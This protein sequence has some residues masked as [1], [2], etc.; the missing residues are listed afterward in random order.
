MTEK[1]AIAFSTYKRPALMVE[2]LHALQMFTTSPRVV[3]I[4]I[5]D[6][7]HA[8]RVVIEESTP[9]K[10]EANI[11]LISMQDRCGIARTKNVALRSILERS[12]TEHI[13]VMEDDVRP[14]KFGWEDVLIETARVNEQKHLLYLPSRGIYG[15]VIKTE[16][17][18]H[19]SIQWKPMCSGLIMYFTRGLLENIGLFEERF[20]APY[21]WEHNEMTARALVAQS[22]EPKFYPH[23][24][25][26]ER[27]EFICSDDERRDRKTSPQQ[28]AV[29]AD[30]AR[31]NRPL[32]DELYT[33]HME[34][35]RSGIT[36]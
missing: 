28:A 10:A 33:Q 24:F 23:C 7:S 35:W 11:E 32:Y 17:Q 18:M 6:A 20:P 12:T 4:A 16:G 27:G 5:D 26:L 2:T 22:I 21:G 36:V 9:Y 30:M 15:P 31:R 8:D 14:V 34:K 3:S 19:R 29:N 1:F 13:I 25:E